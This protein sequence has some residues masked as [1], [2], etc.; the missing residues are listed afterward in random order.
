MKAEFSNP[1]TPE[2]VVEEQVLDNFQ[3]FLHWVED[4]QVTGCVYKSAIAWDYGT[5]GSGEEGIAV[6]GEKYS[7]PDLSAGGVMQWLRLSD[8]IKK[9]VA[10]A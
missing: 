8:D 1:G 5:E 4:E 9:S 6:D 3:D 7:T 2:R 10:V